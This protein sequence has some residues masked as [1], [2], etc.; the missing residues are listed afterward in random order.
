MAVAGAF[1]SAFNVRATVIPNR[2]GAF[3][4][5]PTSHGDRVEKPLIFGYALVAID[6]VVWRFGRPANEVA[7]LLIR[8]CIFAE[9]GRAHV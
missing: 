6:L 1:G 8:L 5:L 9:I 2:V 4:Q 7:R 3:E